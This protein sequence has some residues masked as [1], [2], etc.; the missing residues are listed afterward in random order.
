MAHED[1]PY[2][3]HILDTIAEIDISTY[4]ISKEDFKKNIDKRDANIRRVE[5]IG[6]AVKNI[7]ENTKR[8]YLMLEW[9]KIAGARDV[10]IHQ[11][12]GIDLNLI[13]GII[14]DDIP[15]LKKDVAHL[16][17]ELNGVNK[18]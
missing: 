6:E 16:L 18:K 2:L 8:K 5:I 4:N 12:W 9:K 14:K 3:K 7:S 15:K 17:E 1:I 13:W 10:L 11:Y